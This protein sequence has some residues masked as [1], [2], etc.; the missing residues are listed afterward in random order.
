MN[1]ANLAFLLINIREKKVDLIKIYPL[2]SAFEIAKRISL[3]KHKKYTRFIVRLSIVATS[4]SVAA[5][6]LTFSIVNGFQATITQKIYD[7]SGVIQLNT[8][9]GSLVERN[10]AI[11]KKLKEE[12][13]IT[14]FEPYLHQ[15]I[16]LSFGQEI[17]GQLAKGLPI[18]YQNPFMVQ[19]RNIQSNSG[20]ISREVILSKNIAEK[21]Q[22]GLGDTV[23]IYFINNTQTQERRLKVVG[24]FHTGMEDYDRH[25]LF[26]DIQLLQQVNQ[27]T[28]LIEGYRIQLDATENIATINKSIQN[29]L[30]P[31][32]KSV[33][34][35]ELT[36]QLF[37]W[38]GVQTINRNV[39][40]IIMLLIA[41][42]NL[43]TCLFILILERMPMIGTLNALGAS[44]KTIRQI[45][46]YQISFIT[47][48]G[49]VIGTILG[50]GLSYLQLKLNIIRLD[51]A[52]YLMDTLPI[53]IVPIQVIGVVIGTAIISYLS[54]IIPSFWIRKI[55]P[56][57]TLK[58]D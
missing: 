14:Q 31:N 27:N 25:H 38:I 53:E 57:Q 44:D 21:L 52:A 8:L 16:V 2:S 33:P 46:L 15:S 28:A 42:V 35:M 36:P 23:R 58:S 17:E 4:L 18:T 55:S 13:Q 45:F 30:P 29:S 41:I 50:L 1:N 9:S 48:T 32:W 6:L 54:F 12:K 11:E 10:A 24:F 51:E 3:Q 39:T 5:I 49:I 34:T 26:V 22:I 43:L 19:G 40:I 47:W 56:A 7:F 37:D 20:Q